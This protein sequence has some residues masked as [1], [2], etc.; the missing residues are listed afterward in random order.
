MAY[1]SFGKDFVLETDACLQGLGAILSQTQDDG[2]LHP[3]A[4]ASRALSQSEKNYSVTEVE[5]LAVVWAVSHFHSYLYGH[6]VTVYTDHSAV[7]AVLE[8][9]NPTGRHARWWTR[10]YGRGVK[11]VTI[12]YRSGKENAAADAL[13]RSPQGTP[14]MDSDPQ[15]SSVVSDSVN[16]L[17]QREPVHIQ[18]NHRLFAERQREDPFVSNMTVYLE[19]GTLPDDPHQSQK[20]A[21]LSIHFT[22]LDGILYYIDSKSNNQK[23]AVAPQAVQLQIL[24]E[25]HSGLT[26]GHFSGKRTYNALARHW[27]WEHMYSDCMKY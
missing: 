17:L 6:R 10:V 15:V 2:K 7:K 20:I 21:A 13:S 22:L 26:G 12:V 24:K 19:Q 25:G 5:T 27:W 8:T 23:R 3:I 16:N 18:D 4:C 14:T 11:E 9:P 1:P